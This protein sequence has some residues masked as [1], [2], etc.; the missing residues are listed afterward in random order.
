MNISKGF[1]MKFWYKSL[2]IVAIPDYLC[3][4]L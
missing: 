3:D 1:L 4:L 2:R